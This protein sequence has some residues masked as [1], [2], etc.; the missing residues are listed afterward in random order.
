M[1]KK[2]SDI[3]VKPVTLI[4]AA[5]TLV[6]VGLLVLGKMDEEVARLQEIAIQTRLEK[7]RAEAEKASLEYELSI[8]ESDEYIIAQA[9]NLYN[10]VLKGELVFKVTNLDSLRPLVEVRV[11]Q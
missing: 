3:R 9:R 4:V 10:Y 8:A 11:A 5:L 6:I 2:L 7:A 1:C